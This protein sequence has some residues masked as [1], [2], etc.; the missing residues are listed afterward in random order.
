MKTSIK[1]DLVITKQ[2]DYFQR[3]ELMPFINE[4]VED[5]QNISEDGNNSDKENIIYN[6]IFI[7]NFLEFMDI[8]KM[9]YNEIYKSLIALKNMARSLNGFVFITLNKD[10][11]N[12]KIINLIQYISDYIFRIKPLLL[13][14]DKEKVSNYD[15]IFHIDKFNW[16]NNIRPLDIETN[17]YGLIKDKRKVIIEKIDIGVEIDRNTKVKESDLV[18]NNINNLNKNSNDLEF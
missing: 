8:R 7:T 9:N 13:V 6:R 11:I 17:I 14:P 10:L 5:F 18:K 2:I 4:I 12:K 3:K 15:A 16:I 1:K